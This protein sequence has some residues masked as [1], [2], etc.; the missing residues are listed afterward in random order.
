MP[1]RFTALTLIVPLALGL[2]AFPLS[3]DTYRA[4]NSLMVQSANG[5]DITVPY[6]PRALDNAY[7]CA[8][9]DYIVIAQGRSAKT[10]LFRAT[11]QPR[12]QGQGIGFTT[13]PARAVADSGLSVF[14][15]PDGTVSAGHARSA[16]CHQDP[17]FGFP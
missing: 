15:G 16:F 12:K 3:A 17:F 11:P 9:A 2:T 13:D 1:L 6:T 10:R 14:G 4:S 7:W 5:T 8:A